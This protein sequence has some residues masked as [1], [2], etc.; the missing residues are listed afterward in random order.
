MLKLEAHWRKA[1]ISKLEKLIIWK[2]K[3]FPFFF[4]SNS[5]KQ[6]LQIFEFNDHS[7]ILSL[8][9]NVT[10]YCMNIKQVLRKLA[11]EQTGYR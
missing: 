10:F 4:P 9:V 11:L 7:N 6:P 5:E 8:I 2:S 3:L 1:L